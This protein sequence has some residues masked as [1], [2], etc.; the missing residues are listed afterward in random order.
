MLK[1]L[2]KTTVMTAGLAF[3]LASGDAIAGSTVV[4]LRENGLGNGPI[5]V[6]APD[7]NIWSKIQ[8]GDLTLPVKIRLDVLNGQPIYYRIFQGDEELH[9]GQM[10]NYSEFMPS[11]PSEIEDWP[12]KEFTNTLTGSTTHLSAQKQEIINR[13][14]Q[15]GKPDKNVIFDFDV[16]LRAEASFWLD[17]GQELLDQPDTGTVT[18][19]V[20]CKKAIKATNQVTVDVG[21]YKPQKVEV[22][23]KTFPNDTHQPNPGVT[24]PVLHVTTRVQANTTG[25]ANVERWGKVAGVSTSQ[26]LLIGTNFQGDGTYSGEHTEKLYLGDGTKVS[27]GALVHI[28]DLVYTSLL[29]Q[30][31]IHCEGGGTD[32]APD[33]T[34]NNPDNPNADGLPQ[35]KTLKGDF[36]FVDHGAPKCDRIGKALLTF[37]SPKSDNIHFSLDCKEENHS[38]VV[39]VVPNP[40]GGYMAVK[41]VSFD[42]KKTYTEA[43]TLRTV[44]PYGPKDHVSKTHLFQCVTPSGHSASNDVQVPS[45]PPSAEPVGPATLIPTAPQRAVASCPVHQKLIFTQVERHGILY[46]T[47]KCVDRDLKPASTGQ[48]PDGQHKVIVGT[49]SSSSPVPWWKCVGGSF[50]NNDCICRTGWKPVPWSVKEH[51]ILRHGEKCVPAGPGNKTTVPN[52]PSIKGLVIAKPDAEKRRLKAAKDAAIAKRK[53]DAE[54]AKRRRDA[55]IAKRRRDAAAKAAA[56]AL[57]KRKAAAAVA[58]RKAAAVLI[59]RRAAA[60]ALAQRKAAAAASLV[61]RRS[62][63]K[64]RAAPRSNSNVQQ[65]HAIRRR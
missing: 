9:Y 20:L 64:K 18:V 39:P 7:G 19:P 23:L 43:C 60:A 51:G 29:K 4:D 50:K 27:V 8:P 58:K 41:L 49:G 1:N 28:G 14:N 54:I 45:N 16:E 10:L 13:C 21:P 65:F 53:R 32:Y 33:T 40:A 36:S 2:V 59:Q 35:F 24:C 37:Q 17:G 6:T 38:G 26:D 42:V 44:A 5:V 46:D 34:V 30:T 63:T 48:S 12:L 62:A 11:P 61:R 3:G 57:A 25:I 15:L 31:T 52:D 55:A 47:T 22:F 56:T